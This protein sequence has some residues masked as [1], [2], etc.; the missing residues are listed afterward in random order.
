M[1]FILIVCFVIVMMVEINNNKGNFKKN[2]LEG[3][4]LKVEVEG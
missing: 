1:I 3:V 4:K 2:R